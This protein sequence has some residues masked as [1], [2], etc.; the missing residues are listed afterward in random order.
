MVCTVHVI[1]FISSIREFM[2]F[3]S[4]ILVERTTISSRTSVKE[5]GIFYWIVCV[6]W[7]DWTNWLQIMKL[8]LHIVYIH[9]FKKTYLLKPLTYKPCHRNVW[10]YLKVSVLLSTGCY[11]LVECLLMVWQIIR[12]IPH[13]GYI[14]LFLIPQCSITGITKAVVCALLSLA[15]A[16]KSSLATNW[17]E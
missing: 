8:F 2:E 6:S 15:G 10:L 16:Y 1:C 3:T 13:G 11:S 5:Q 7:C 17:K 4:K 12:S 14:E 9:H